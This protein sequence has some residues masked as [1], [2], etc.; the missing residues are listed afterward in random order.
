[1]AIQHHHQANDFRAGFEVAKW[2]IFYH[3]ARLPSHPA[4]L[5]QFSLTVPK[6]GINRKTVKFV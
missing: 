1:M 2:R 4:R 6:I 5:K 3:S